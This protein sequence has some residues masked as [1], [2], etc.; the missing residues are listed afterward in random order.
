MAFVVITH[1]HPEHESVMADI[2]QGDT[3]MHVSQVTR[4]VDV[5]PDHVYVIISL[6]DPD[7]PDVKGYWLRDLKIADA[8]IAIT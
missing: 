4:K 1:L 8:E 6:E 2:L 5:E 3:K 7:A